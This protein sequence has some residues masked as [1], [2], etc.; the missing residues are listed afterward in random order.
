M[1]S[2]VV[3]H[4]GEQW[5]AALDTSDMFEPDAGKGLLASFEPLTNYKVRHLSTGFDDMQQQ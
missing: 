5:R 4:D 1:I 3:W 2:C